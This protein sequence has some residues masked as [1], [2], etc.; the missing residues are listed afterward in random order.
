MLVCLQRSSVECDIMGPFCTC[1]LLTFV[2][3]ANPEGPL[4]C[5]ASSWKQC[6]DC[7]KW[8][9]MSNDQLHWKSW[10]CRLWD[11]R[12]ER[13]FCR[14]TTLPSLEPLVDSRSKV[15][16]KCMPRAMGHVVFTLKSKDQ[17][18]P[19]G[20]R[21]SFVWIILKPILC[22]VL[23]FRGICCTP[24]FVRMLREPG[25]WKQWTHRGGALQI[26]TVSWFTW[27]VSVVSLFWC[28]LEMSTLESRGTQKIL[29]TVAIGWCMLM[30]GQGGFI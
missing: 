14:G 23:D 3:T 24:T 22:L 16:Y 13:S 4:H 26:F 20:G 29:W 25:G 1:C 19:R 28:V 5:L 10:K 17:T 9:M 2:S 12:R 15:P 6:Q 30:E 11:V 27:V 21:E 7:V 18:F 8:L